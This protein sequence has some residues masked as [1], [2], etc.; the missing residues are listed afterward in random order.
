MKRNKLFALLA[1]TAALLIVIT[2]FIYQSYNVKYVLEQEIIM[3]VGIPSAF[4]VE[5]DRINFGR[6]KPDSFAT[7]FLNISHHDA[8]PLE[9]VVIAKGDISPYLSV[10]ENFFILEPGQFKELKIR[11]MPKNDTVFGV[12]TGTLQVIFRKG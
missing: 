10:S 12:Y 1:F 5:T 7:R 4:N 3:E 9:V 8:Y 11:A 6:V 2:A